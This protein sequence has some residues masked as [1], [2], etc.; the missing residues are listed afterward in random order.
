MIIYITQL[1]FI[2]F[3]LVFFDAVFFSKKIYFTNELK[4]YIITAAS[5]VFLLYLENDLRWIA[6]D[7]WRFCICLSVVSVDFP[8]FPFFN[9]FFTHYFSFFKGKAFFFMY[10]CQSHNVLACKCVFR[11][12][13]RVFN[14]V[15]S[16][17]LFFFPSLIFRLTKQGFEAGFFLFFF[18]TIAP[19]EYIIYIKFSVV[20][21]L[22]FR[23]Q[24]GFIFCRLLKP[25]FHNECLLQHLLSSFYLCI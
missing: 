6:M 3:I 15:L 2:F 20:T 17:C 1:V 4:K 21:T 23:P 7:F 19:L 24:P 18:M 10:S 16:L 22:F 5:T 8:F 14:I 13:K 11:G 12:Q 9:F 25:F